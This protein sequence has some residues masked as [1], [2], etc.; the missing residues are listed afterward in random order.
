MLFSGESYHSIVKRRRM[1]E[2]GLETPD[3]LPLSTSLRKFLT[4]DLLRPVHMLLTEPIVAFICLYVA[5]IFGTL[6]MFFGTF[7]YIFQNTCK[8][9]KSF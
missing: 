5:C 6:F 3:E 4:V 2:L 8:C 1:M 7:F 9:Y